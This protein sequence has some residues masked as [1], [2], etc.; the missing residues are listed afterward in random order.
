MADNPVQLSIPASSQG[1]IN[2]LANAAYYQRVTLAW[3]GHTIVFAGSG[4]GQPMTTPDG[5][6]TYAIL[7]TPGAFQISATFEFSQTGP[8]GTFQKASVKDPVISDKA[9]FHV[10]EVTSE[11]STDNDNNDSYLTIATVSK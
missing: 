6:T 9:G 2:C 3:P 11:D 1:I 10:I 4:E 7:P 8:S 5:S